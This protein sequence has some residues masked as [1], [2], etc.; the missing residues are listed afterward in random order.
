MILPASPRRAP[1][2]LLLAALLA[3][4]AQGPHPS[5]AA[6][7]PEWAFLASDLAPDPA[8]HFGKLA[9]GMRYVLAHNGTPAGTASVRLVIDAGSLDEG[10]D[11]RGFAHFVEHMA[12]NGSTHVPEGEMIRLLERKGLAFG[13]DTN[14]QTSFEHT[15][16]QLD[17][18][19]ADPA[20]LDT[21]LMLMR[22]TASELSF[23]PGAV[24]RER[25]VVLSEMRDGKGYQLANWEDQAKFLYPRATYRNR[26]PIGTA[27]AVGGAR[28]QA[29]RAFWQAHYVPAKATLVVVGDFPLATLEQ[30]V[31]GHF[32][33][34]HAATARARSDQGKVEPKRRDHI[35]IW[36]DPA[37]SER[38]T[39]SR[40]GPWLDEP[41]TIANRRR[42]LLRQIGYAIVNRRFQSLSRRS[43]PPFR[44]AGFGTGE[45]FH[46]GRTTNL[47]VDTEDG[48]WQRGLVTAAAVLRQALN[49]GFTP[50]EVSEQLANIRTSLE[51][52]A[53]EADT[54]P[55]GTLVQS[56]IALVT[57]D[58]VPTSP[59]SGLA[60]FNAYADTIT[61]E[62]VLAALRE[63]AVPLDHPLI[64][65]QG[66]HAP[67]GGA[68]AMAAAW[69]EAQ[70]TATA[71]FTPVTGQ[72][73]YGD[74]GRPGTVVSDHREPL[75][76]I[77][78]VRFANGVRLNLRH[79]DLD[80]DRISLR[81]SID[82]GDLVATRANPLA[83]EMVP[84]LAQGG[85]GKHSQDELQTLLAGHSV[86]GGLA[87]DDDAFVTTVTTTRRDLALQLSY[88]TALVSDPGYRPEAEVLFRE[89]MTNF[90]ARRDATPQSAMA[91]ALGGILS[92]GDPRFTL[93]DEAAYRALNFARLRSDIGDR[94]AHGAIEIG[95]VGD[96]DE[97]ATIAAIGRTFGALPPREAEFR[98]DS[99]PHERRFTD[100]RGPVVVRHK[101]PAEQAIVRM[102]W[103]TTDDSDARL[104]LTLDLL[105]DIV[106]IAVQDTVRE[107]MGKS[108]SPGASSS[109]SDVW[110]H[111]GTFA[112]QASV[113]TGDVPATRAAFRKTI[114]ALIAGPIDPDLIN[115]ARAPLAQRLDNALKGNGGW[116]AMADRA[117]SRPHDIE[118]FTGAKAML[119]GITAHDVQAAAARFLD[120]DRAVEVLVLPQAAPFP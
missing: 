39:A 18:P 91:N 41:D 80:R 63:E 90:F 69:D 36:T 79:T 99:L 120:P 30:A 115:R 73:G 93:Q 48:K 118:R 65:F 64:R 6:P 67:E 46:I 54:R 60:R 17:L 84:M 110:R 13:A 61:P 85:L 72:F 27:Q 12:F 108:Y 20:L 23:T 11:E 88:L 5:P 34:W 83:V 94:L 82:G 75:L 92:D 38:V 58:K 22:E 87:S 57:D 74:F 35:D 19:R 62:R 77:R 31:S 14:A 97:E 21:A 16:Y 103:P 15:I 119:A 45:V 44:G 98:T 78:E 112:V 101:G 9:N 49:D 89:N 24:E 81:L 8:L 95:L 26:M 32:A 100:R 2:V 3:G 105:Q 102:V 76:G 68:R 116:L 51:N 96:C 29:L 1:L 47:V 7:K 37:L 117:Q 33:D 25:G 113:A 53:A 66:R 107:A 59:Q 52:A 55:H 4:C 114:A 71:P 50:A 70:H 42:N 43:D 86:S 10:K 28:A 109:Q 40:I 104:S 56:A 111:W 106:T